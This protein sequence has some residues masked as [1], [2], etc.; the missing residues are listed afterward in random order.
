MYQYVI[1]GEGPAGLQLSYYFEKHHINY[2]ILEKNDHVASFFDHYPRNRKLISFN[3]IYSIYND[4]EIQLRWDWNS[5]LTDDYSHL[6]K[7]YSRKFYPSADELQAYLRDFATKY[8]TKIQFNTKVSGVSKI[9]GVFHIETEGAEVIRCKR[10][11]VA[12]GVSDPFVPTIP[13]IE[14]VDETYQN[15]SMNPEDFINQRVLIIGKANS[16]FEIADNLLETTSL[17]HILSPDVV[18]FAWETRFSGH[19]RANYINILD[20]YQL[21][22]LNSILDADIKEI[23]KVGE[24]FHVTLIYKH[25]DGEIDKLVFDRIILATGFQFD[26]S[27]FSEEIRPNPI[28][29]GRLPEMTS[30]WEGVSTNDVYYA[31]TLTQA[32]D[33]Q[34]A[35]SSFIDG[36]RY[37][38]RTLF[39]ILQHRYHKKPLYLYCKEI[40][41]DSLAHSIMQRINRSS[42]LWAQFGYLCD[43]IYLEDN[44]YY[45]YHELPVNFCHDYFK[46]KKGHYL[47]ITF[48]WGDAGDNVFYTSRHPRADKAYTNA[49]L[50]PIIR[51]YKSGIKLTEHHVLE[52]LFGMY[53]HA[54]ETGTVISH[55]KL[56]MEEYHHIHH[57][58]PLL[59]YLDD[60]IMLPS[61]S[62]HNKSKVPS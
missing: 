27:I 41:R 46:N 36:F 6:F 20:T 51:Q 52:D 45:Y 13:G 50:H 29:R 56:E 60:V 33:F 38:S 28:C 12:T 49:F 43:A 47:L 11:I 8:Q 17:V 24:H 31:G 14:H 18:K 25:A 7:D 48:N 3:K 21:K 55:G 16:A 19:L 26:F 58:K 2:L 44:Q 35:S 15:V 1:I 23:K 40:N 39:H 5:L 30:A 37:N 53:H 32:Q 10:L 61:S 42:A 59:A 57:H 22:L 9:D 4:P 62:A 54:G 34:Q